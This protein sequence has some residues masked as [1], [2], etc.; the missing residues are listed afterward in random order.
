MQHLPDAR[1]SRAVLIGASAYESLPALPTVAHNVR[2]LRQLLCDPAIWGL[3]PEACRIVLDPAKS[4]DIIDPIT[5]AAQEA[6]DTLVVYYAGHGLAD[7]Y[8][9]SDLHLCLLGSEEAKGHTALQFHY[10]RRA[11]LQARAPRR[12]VILDCCFSG[13]ASLDHMNADSDQ[14]ARNAVIE[15]TYVLSSSAAD[16]ESLAPVDEPFTAFTGEL[17]ALIRDG[18]PR[19]P[20]FISVELLHS[21]LQQRLRA[22]ARPIPRL[23]AQNIAGQLMLA[24]NVAHAEPP[25]VPKPISTEELSALAVHAGLEL[26]ALLHATAHTREAADVLAALWE[27]RD[28]DA[29]PGSFRLHLELAAMRAELGQRAEAITVLEEAFAHIEDDEARFGAEVAEVCLALARLLREAM[30]YARACDVLEFAVETALVSAPDRPAG[31]PV[32]EPRPPTA[33]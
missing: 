31:T 9:H 20:E 7:S 18:I 33:A 26:A 11:V 16:V 25:P 5:Q 21:H 28:P 17:V 32:T 15:G 6:D 8:G 22:R 23:S 29:A 14:V 30:E 12:V 24:R 2:A 1:T 10:V 13:R 4:Q 19:G 3:A 27:A